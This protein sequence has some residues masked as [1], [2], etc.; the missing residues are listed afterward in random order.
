MA[1][2][3]TT[4]LKWTLYHHDPDNEDWSE[5]SY[6]KIGTPANF[7]EMFAMMKEI[8]SARFLE[9]MY[10]WMKDP[11][12]PMWENKMNKRGGSYS[13]KIHQDHALECFERYMTAAIMNLIALDAENTIVGVSISP[14]KGFNII[15]LWNLHSLTYKAETDVRV[16]VSQITHVDIIYRPHVDQKMS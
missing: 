8:G 2:E 14:K 9:G 3:M 1:E 16:L 13:I 7:E 15:K 4:P 6:K 5:E 10:F 11:Y 12:P